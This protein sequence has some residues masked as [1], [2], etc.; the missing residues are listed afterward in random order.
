M[1][2][3]TANLVMGP[4]EWGLLVLLSVIWGASF[5]FG[6]IAVAE[7]P[8]LSVA[9]L[10]V[11]IAAVVLAVAIRV[12]GGEFPKSIAGWTPYLA[13]G[14]L[15]NVIPFSL[16]FW[17]QQE[18]G[19]GLASVLNAT[20]PLFAAGLA[21]MLTSEEKV[22]A[23]KLAGVLTGI[24]GVAVLVGPSALSGAGGH[25]LAE[26]A[27]LG[28]ACSYGLAGVY[29]RRFRGTPALTSAC[30][31]LV[32][33]S[34]ILAPLVWLIDRP[35]SLVLPGQQAVGAILGLAILCT[36]IAY[37][38]FFTI[39]R[40]AGATNVMLVTLLIPPS[41]ILLG[42]LV[43]GEQMEASELVGSAIIGLALVIIDG[44]LPRRLWSG[45]AHST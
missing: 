6:R 41:A 5:L 29:G 14:L 1:S 23:L 45:G 30:C 3:A 2:R 8:P 11:A 34:L 12:T 44:R 19:A 32:C 18:I 22:T 38:I 17:G 37:V 21:H 31:Q 13:M 9:F 35:E 4:A 28:A 20:T 25:W 16:I 27:V 40:R 10:R 42:A 39:I 26:A 43:L 36:S 33:S 15:N 7:V 24:A